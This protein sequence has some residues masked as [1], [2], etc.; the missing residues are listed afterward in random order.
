MVQLNFLK[1]KLGQ[2][3]KFFGDPRVFEL[4]EIT[5]AGDFVAQS[6]KRNGEMGREKRKVFTHSKII[7]IE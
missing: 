4:N 6:I 5:E 1:M 2:R 7:L 3:F